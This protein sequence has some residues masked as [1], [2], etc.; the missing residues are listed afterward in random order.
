MAEEHNVAY[1]DQPG[2]LRDQPAPAVAPG[3]LSVKGGKRAVKRYVNSWFEG[4][5]GSDQWLVTDREYTLGI[6]VDPQRREGSRTQGEDTF[7]EPQA[8]DEAWLDV[9]VAV[10]SEDFEVLEKPAKR[11]KVPRSLSESSQAAT[12]RVRPTKNNQAVSISVY[13]YYNNNL[14]HEALVSAATRGQPMDDHAEASAYVSTLNMY[15]RDLDEQPSDLNIRV[16]IPKGKSE[17]RM[18]LFYDL[19]GDAFDLLACNL[20]VSPERLQDLL[21]GVHED[22]RRLVAFDVFAEPGEKLRDARREGRIPRLKNLDDTDCGR[23]LQILARAGRNLFVTLFDSSTGGNQREREQVHQMGERLLSLSAGRQLKL[24][25]LSDAFFIPWN[26][27]YD[28]DYPAQ[29]V[30]PLGFWGFRHVIEEIPYRVQEKTTQTVIEIPPGQLPLGLNVNIQEDCLPRI[31]SE[32]QAALMRSQA[33]VAVHERHTEAEVLAA[34]CGRDGPY[35][36]EYFFCH[37]GV[38]GE[39]G[40]SF[41]KSY[42][43]LTQDAGGLTLDDIKLAT[44]NQRFPNCPLFILNACESGRMDGRFYDG[45]VPKFMNM[46]ACAVVGTDNTVPALFGAHFGLELLRA[47]LQGEALGAALRA[48]RVRLMEAHHNPLGLIYRVFGDADVRLSRPVL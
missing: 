4:L 42:L 12:F 17:Y 9:V 44:F 14:F 31:L 26:L 41:D 27:L 21:Q 33:Q 19:G 7:T 3:P 45:F 38:G 46:G 30:D 28:G 37:A 6:Q 36:V 39:L 5:K 47:F 43:G 22:V 20:L 11:I 10:S 15:R 34:F 1:P 40:K 29:V 18:T 48:V 25:V 13:F 24:Q 23:A 35:E 32:P 16:V 2:V 8:G